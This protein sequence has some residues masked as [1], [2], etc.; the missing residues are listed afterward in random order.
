[1]PYICYFLTV[2][3]LLSVLF[4]ELSDFFSI[5]SANFGAAFAIMLA[6]YENADS[7]METRPR[8]MHRANVPRLLPP[9]DRVAVPE[10]VL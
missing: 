7:L 5:G 4:Y 2:A 8:I 9:A 10:G 6:L 3:A 1:M